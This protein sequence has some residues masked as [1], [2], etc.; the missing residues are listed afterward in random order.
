[1]IGRENKSYLRVYS[2]K[3]YAPD[4]LEIECRMKFFLFFFSDSPAL[5]S[6]VSN[7]D[8]APFGLNGSGTVHKMFKFLYLMAA[9]LALFVSYIFEQVWP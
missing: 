1:M 6:S 2:S 4:R 5:E 7:P 8:A 3:I 9:A